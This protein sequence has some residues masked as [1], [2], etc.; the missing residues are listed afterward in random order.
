MLEPLPAERTAI[1]CRWLFR[2]KED[3]C[4]KARLVA[5]GYSQKQGID[6]QEIFAPVAKF[7]TIQM[8]LV[9]GC[10]S[11]WE[12]QGMD[13]KTAF[14]N[15]ELEE[16]VYLEVPEG[17]LIPSPPATP[18]YQPPITCRLLKS[19]YGLKQSPRAWYSRIDKFF[20]SNTFTR[21]DTDH[22]LFINYE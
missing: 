15:S 2:R 14:L 9:V 3:G 19:I 18:E 10:E 22:S 16:T 8:L 21:C 7:T 13:I 12:I 6:Y 1:G 4:Y 11:D 5:K 20:R 17:V